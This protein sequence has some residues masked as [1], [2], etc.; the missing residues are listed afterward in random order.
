MSPIKDL[1]KQWIGEKKLCKKGGGSLVFG[2]QKKMAK[3][4]IRSFAKNDLVTLCAPPQWGK[5][6]V[7]LYVSYIM[8]QKK[9]IDPSNVFF[10]TA[11]SDRS[12]V[13]QTKSRVL[14]MWR[15]NVYHRNT[16]NSLEARIKR[17]KE[18]KK[19]YPGKDLRRDGAKRSGQT[20]YKKHQDPSDLSNPL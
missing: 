4:I 20:K 11:M 13:Q 7:S 14:P 15:K 9:G 1:R 5:T 18:E 17:M 6:G 19:T 16:L 10:I 12:W 3:R 8:S 2:D